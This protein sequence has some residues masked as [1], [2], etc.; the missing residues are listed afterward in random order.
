MTYVT[1][2]RNPQALL[3]PDLQ[4]HLRRAIES[5]A[6]IAP[7]GF[8]TIAEDLYKFVVEPRQFLAL[9][10]EDGQ[11]KCSCAGFLPGSNLF[12]YPTISFLYNEG[13]RALCRE[14]QAE[15]MDFMVSNGYTQAL[16]VNTSGKNDAAWL[17]G[18]TPE[19]AKSKVVG[20]LVHFEVK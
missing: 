9:G 7:A 16:V 14:V 17:R 6:F 8:D 11:W 5:M 15:V 2:L 19:G 3:L 18:L 12:P 20:S 1:I 13:T 10:A 4:N